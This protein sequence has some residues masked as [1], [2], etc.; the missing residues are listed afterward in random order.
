MATRTARGLRLEVTFINGTKGF[1]NYEG[2]TEA[3]LQKKLKALGG[4][5]SEGIREVHSIK[6]HEWHQESTDWIM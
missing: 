3:Q 5:F 1:R 6:P 2:F 4:K